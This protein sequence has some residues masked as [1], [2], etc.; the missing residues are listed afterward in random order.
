VALETALAASEIVGGAGSLDPA[1]RAA[2]EST[3]CLDAIRAAQAGKMTDM[4][5]AAKHLAEG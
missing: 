3:A 1:A 2:F 5:L 4:D